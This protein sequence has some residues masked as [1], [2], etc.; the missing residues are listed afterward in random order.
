MVTSAR[1]PVGDLCSVQAGDAAA[2][3]D[4]LAGSDAGDPGQQHAVAAGVLEQRARTGQHGQPA[5]HLAHRTQ[6]RQRAGVGLDGLVRDR[7]GAGGQQRC[8]LGLVGR[9]V[10]VG[11]QHLVRPKE[12]VLGSDRLLDLQQQVGLAPDVGSR[13]DDRGAG[14]AVVGIGD[15]GTGA[16]SGLHEHLVAALREVVNAGRGDGH[17]V[18]LALD[19]CRD[20]DLHCCCLSLGW[21]Q[22]AEAVP[23]GASRRNTVERILG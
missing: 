17:P 22:C 11:E 10:Q 18:L 3:H 16:G 21:Q 8:G 12:A 19:L 20:A 6:Q 9:E 23:S 5:G 1:K 13:L 7:R 14:R 15:R 4:D 2:D